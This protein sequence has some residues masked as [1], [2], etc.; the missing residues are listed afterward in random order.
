MNITVQKLGVGKSLLCLQ[1][2]HLFD[3]KYSKNH[4]NKY[5]INTVN[6]MWN[7]AV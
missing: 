6:T 3:Q 7:T 4:V 2:L 1:W 5:C